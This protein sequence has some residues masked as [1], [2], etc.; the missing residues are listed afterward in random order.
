M[1][2]TGQRVRLA[3]VTIACLVVATSCGGGGGYDSGN[4]P[5]GPSNPGGGTIPTV[6]IRSGG[7]LDPQEIRIATGQQ[8]RFVNEDTQ[9]HHPQSNPHLQHTDCPQANVAVVNPGQSVTTQ[10]FP[11]AKTCGYHDHMNPDNTRLHGII[12]IGGDTGPGG[13][14]YVVHQ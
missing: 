5:T 3:C 7:T 14:V 9:P 1:M 10:A 2:A 6:T 4:S 13:P 8:V 11:T 12:R